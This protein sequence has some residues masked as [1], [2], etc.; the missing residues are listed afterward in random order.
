MRIALLLLALAMV[1][2][3]LYCN[4]VGLPGFVRR[5]LLAELQRQGIQLN[6]GQLRWAFYRGVVASQVTF[7]PPGEADGLQAAAREIAIL[8]DLSALWHRRIE[9]RQVSVN[10]AVFRFSLPV[11]NGPPLAFALTNLS[12]AFDLLPNGSVEMRHFRASIG[13]VALDLRGTLDHAAEIGRWLSDTNSGS[14]TKTT[15]E[16]PA[17][18]G[19]ALRAH[20]ETWRKLHFANPP[21]LRLTL[22]ADAREWRR[23][24]G[25]LSIKAPSAETP[26]GTFTNFQAQVRLEAARF[27]SAL[28]FGALEL[29]ADAAETPWATAQA[30]MLRLDCPPGSHATNVLNASVTFS[31]RTAQTRWGKA[32]SAHG[33]V[34]WTQSTTNPVPLNAQGE[35]VFTRAET[36]WA[37]AGQAR[38]VGQF[39][40]T[41]ASVPP[42]WGWWT[43]VAPYA[44]EWH[45]E[46]EDLTA[47][48]VSTRYTAI[49]GQWQPPLLS[50]SNLFAVLHGGSFSLGA[51][52]D[53]TT[54][55]AQARVLADCD[56]LALQWRF[57]AGL[58]NWLNRI[59]Y[60]GTPELC[61]EI[62]ARF[63]PW[64]NAMTG[65][66]ADTL[67]TLVADGTFRTQ[68]G[69]YLGM[70]VAAAEGRVIYSNRV[71]R[72]SGPDP[73]H[74]WL[75][76]RR[77]EGTV[78]L[79]HLANDVTGDVWW[80]IRSSIDPNVAR[81]VLG[82]GPEKG[83][84]Q[85]Q[86][87]T[88]PELA[89]Q[90]WMNGRQG[91]LLGLAGSVAASNVVARG[92]P[93]TFL[94]AAVDF[95]NTAVRFFAPEI[96]FTN[97]VVR[98]DGLL[99]DLAPLRLT[100]TNGFSDGPPEQ[101]LAA[102]G[103]ANLVRTLAD[104]QFAAPPRVRLNGVIPLAG[105]HDFDLLAEV[106]GGPFHWWRITTPHLRG[107]VHYL[108]HRLE[109]RDLE[110]TFYGGHMQMAAD[111][112]IQPGGATRYQFSATA[113]N[114]N[115][116]EMIREM[117]QRTNSI[118]G[119]LD[120]RLTV[121]NAYT[122][123]LNTWNGDGSLALRDGL[124]WEHPVFSVV[125]K[126]INTLSPGLGNV[127]FRSG[128]GAV[129]ITNGVFYA[130][131]M[132]LDSALLQLK[133]RGGV[134]VDRRV[135]AV[136]QA[137]PLQNVVLIG[138]LLNSILWP[139][140]KALEF[141][142]TNTLDD[143]AV[144][145]EHAPAKLLFAPLRPFHLLRSIFGP[146]KNEPPVYQPLPEPDSPSP[147]PAPK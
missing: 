72:L 14:A 63:P 96:H 130:K 139:M 140:T 108:G 79:Q 50:V 47:F 26:W 23:T 132:V 134:D 46:A 22:N 133:L 75:H 55:A 104:Y 34:Q 145:P 35:L 59:K 81:P 74:P 78:D 48:D 95:T 7:G 144:E 115:L 98:A 33:S 125:S 105:G 69:S 110:G 9:L 85:F 131:G 30:V 10:G 136:V 42:D 76:A 119:Q 116:Q 39:S 58:S 84:D 129:T 107:Q 127:R 44:A 56:V 11:T 54:R 77:P 89:L 118:A 24:R 60:S 5:P 146:G 2:V 1:G 25:F 88:P 135:D 97:G 4:L 29:T 122:T 20:L 137:R 123:N 114:A 100:L 38:L 71:L 113:T 86:F 111:F 126:F 27:H 94:R 36:P 93:A 121:T 31:A 28:P 66:G 92:Q 87:S 101:I 18:P 103:D 73:G 65:F 62:R 41:F 80:N 8:P 124:I 128:S 147:E 37:S 142:V 120:M 43:N 112:D 51:Q 13:E 99:L 16:E 143:P 15:S 57:P 90:L 53:V 12:A 102:I 117:G 52:V 138:P 106:E 64:T 67:A 68:A 19:E 91:G 17:S 45:L 109:L 70:E 49:E 83:L 141:R 61:A 3:T 21:E 40:P 32:A 82:A 6:C